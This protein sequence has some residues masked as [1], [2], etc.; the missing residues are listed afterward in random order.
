MEEYQVTFDTWQPTNVDLEI[1]IRREVEYN[2]TPPQ[3]KRIVVY[4]LTERSEKHRLIVKLF[5][6]DDYELGT[7]SIPGWRGRYPR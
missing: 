1:D 3:L 4:E 2:I 5:D 6:G 7:L